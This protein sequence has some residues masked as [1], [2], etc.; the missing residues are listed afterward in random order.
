MLVKVWE[1]GGG[2][3][4]D[5]DAMMACYMV[6]FDLNWVGLC[7]RVGS[8]ASSPHCNVWEG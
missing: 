5:G 8:V 6:L 2:E 4:V 7:R 3:E 1:S